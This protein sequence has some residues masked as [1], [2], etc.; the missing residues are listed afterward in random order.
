M[1]VEAEDLK[2]SL[3]LQLTS[4]SKQRGVLRSRITKL[5][6]TIKSNFSS[7][8]EQ[9][10]ALNLQRLNTLY[11]DLQQINNQ[12]LHL[13]IELDVSAEQLELHA[14][15]EEEYE[16]AIIYAL[17]LLQP[18]LATAQQ[19]SGNAAPPAVSQVSQNK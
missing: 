13:N 3:Q 4:L 9:L 18:A 1:S 5:T 15:Q 6:N 10:R 11:S 8:E 7:F 2:Q 16:D 19:S 17:S 14:A 12:I